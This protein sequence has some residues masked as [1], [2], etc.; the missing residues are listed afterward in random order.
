MQQLLVQLFAAVDTDNNGLDPSELRKVAALLNPEQDLQKVSRTTTEDHL[1]EKNDVMRRSASADS[2]EDLSKL[3]SFIEEKK[4]IVG[5]PGAGL[6]VAI[7]YAGATL[8]KDGRV[9]IDAM[10]ELALSMNRSAL[11]YFHP[12][13]D[14]DLTLMADRALR[15]TTCRYATVFWRRW[16]IQCKSTRKCKRC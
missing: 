4:A 6:E 11:A 9:P 2:N 1:K 13:P 14:P 8:S 10:V 16:N 5:L 3:R 7:E 15:G 12:D